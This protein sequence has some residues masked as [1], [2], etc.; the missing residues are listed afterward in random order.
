MMVLGIGGGIIVTGANALA[1]D[2]KLEAL[3]T[4]G[5]FNLLNL[6]FGLGGLLTPLIAANLFKNDSARCWFLPAGSR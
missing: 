5:V 6:F 4:A 3:S 1:G 2:V